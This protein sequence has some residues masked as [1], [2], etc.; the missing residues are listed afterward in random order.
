MQDQIEHLLD[1]SSTLAEQIGIIEQLNQ[2][3]FSPAVLLELAQY[4]RS[5]ALKIDRLPTETIDIVGTGGDGFDT[6]NFSTMSAILAAR[7]SAKVAKHGNKGST[8]KCGSFDLLQKMDV[9]IP[10]NPTDAKVEF[11]QHGLVFLFAP[12]FHPIMKNVAA[13]RKVFAERG[14]RTIFNLMGPLLNPASV[15]RMLVGVYKKELVE[16]Y[17][18]VLKQLGVEYGI[19]AYGDGLDELTV[20]GPSTVAIIKPGEI[21]LEEWQPTDFGFEHANISDITGGSP[22]ENLAETKLLLA[23]QLPGPKTD[24]VLFNTGAALSVASGFE[25][26]VQEGINQARAQLL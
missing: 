1:P 10:E 11:D 23:G 8:S 24:M 4:L 17:A 16:P 22:E 20:T 15:T 26:S 21:T 14:E 2:Q 6:L 18:Q 5:K 7:S 25:L 19:V 12:Y 9:N 13:A 3:Q